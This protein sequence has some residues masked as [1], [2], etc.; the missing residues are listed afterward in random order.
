[1]IPKRELL[2]DSAVAG[3]HP[4][5]IEKDYALGWALAGIFSQPE[6]AEN[7]LFKGGTCIRKCHLETYRFSEDLDFTLK[8]VA[9]L[10]EDFLRRVLGEM[11]D[12]VHARTGLRFSPA[13]RA[14]EIYENPRG[15]ISAQCKI[16][17][18]GPLAPR[19]GAIPNIKLDLT[20][21]ERLVL[22]P[23]HVSVRHPYSDAPEG[24]IDVLAYAYEEAF[25]EKIRALAE[26]T[27]PRDL[28]DV[29]SFFRNGEIRSGIAV[30]R[31]VLEE[32]CR[33]KGIAAPRRGDLGPHRT[34]LEHHWDAM[35]AHQL[36]S[37]PPVDAIWD[38]LPEFFAWL[39]GERVAS[40]PP[41]LP[42][43]QGEAT[44]R[45][46]TSSLPLR[47]KKKSHLEVIRFS[48][49]NRLCVDLDYDG[50]AQRVEPYSL[51]RTPQGDF[52]LHA[53]NER[54]RVLSGYRLDRIQGARMTK[55]SFSPRHQIE[56]VPEMPPPPARGER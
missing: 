32:K 1:M 51:R 7:W 18:A 40:P 36:L 17:Y 34:D 33:F 14:V 55:R 26:R 56:L 19:A 15:N 30:V 49:A 28:Y 38:A 25:A 12:W 41:P 54:Q 20:A 8:D 4:R 53:W 35:L 9:H 37:V 3:I 31:E 46:P 39:D 47:H 52:V 23:A 6:L 13:R 21:D 5:L 43:A 29:V 44:V 48:A 42:L 11:S 2:N 27:L 10:D 50:S 22:P 24:G 45:E 16:G